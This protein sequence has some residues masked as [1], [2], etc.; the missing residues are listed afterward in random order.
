M[1][2]ALNNLVKLMILFPKDDIERIN[3]LTIKS[4]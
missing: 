2:L 3:S 1:Y 4:Q